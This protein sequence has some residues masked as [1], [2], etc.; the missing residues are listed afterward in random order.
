MGLIIRLNEL[1]FVPKTHSSIFHF[2]F[3]LLEFNVSFCLPCQKQ[4]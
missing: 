2:L 1:V 4:L 3:S